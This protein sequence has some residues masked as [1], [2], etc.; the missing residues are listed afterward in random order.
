MEKSFKKNLF[1]FILSTITDGFSE[2]LKFTAGAVGD[3][4]FTAIPKELDKIKIADKSWDTET[5]GYT[6]FFIPDTFLEYVEEQ[7]GKTNTEKKIIQFVIKPLFNEINEL[8]ETALSALN[9]AKVLLPNKVYRKFNNAIKTVFKSI[10]GLEEEF[11]KSE[12]GFLALLLSNA[13]IV[14]AMLCGIYNS[15]V[16]VVSGII[17]L[18]GL[19][20]LGIKEAVDFQNNL[21]YYS[22]LAIEFV[23]NIIESIL[24]IDFKALFTQTLLLPLTLGQLIFN[25]GATA[26]KITVEQVAYFIGYLIGL[27]IETIISILFSGG[28]ITLNKVIAKT[29]KEP[30]EFLLKTF[31]AGVKK[32]SSIFQKIIN[33]VQE[34]LKALKNPK[35]LAADIKKFFEDLFGVSVKLKDELDLIIDDVIKGRT[36]LSSNKIKGN[37]GEIVAHKKVLSLKTINGKPVKYEALHDIVKS[38]DQKITKGID[39]LYVNKLYDGKPPPNKYLINEAKFNTATLGN[40]KSKGRQMESKWIE[41]SLLEIRNLKRNLRNDILD[42]YDPIL[43]KINK[44]GSVR[45]VNLLDKNAKKIKDFLQ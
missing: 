40:T 9:R 2:V 38:L 31:K 3:F 24:E 5:Q 28:T 25:A 17:Q 14:N 11:F 19:V 18:V 7:K 33:A 10:D 32:A 27:I 23:E 15:L 20:F 36:K 22:A 16:D 13:R 42:S 37:F 45:D 21:G 35:K 8:E 6:P 26:F 39:G 34:I 43:T 12:N 30:V 4:L 41:K 44:N 1:S 29:F